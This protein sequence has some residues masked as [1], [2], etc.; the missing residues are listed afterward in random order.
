MALESGDFK[1]GGITIG[2][3]I[4]TSRIPG[5]LQAI[6]GML[7][8]FLRDSQAAVNV[9]VRG[10]ATGGGA[11]AGRAASAPHIQLAD[12]SAGMAAVLAKA[13]AKSSRAFANLGN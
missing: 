11:P 12:P 13:G 5:D 1:H 7:D 6:S 4:D 3:R 10:S 9:R 8:R 2:A